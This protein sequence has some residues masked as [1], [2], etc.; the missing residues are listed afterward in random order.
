[1]KEIVRLLIVTGFLLV[2]AGILLHFLSALTGGE[3]LPGDII[4]KGSRMTF[5]FPIVS[6]IVV[7]IAITIILNILFRAH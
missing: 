3:K 7:S 4:V 5:Y 2:A 1:M 6:C